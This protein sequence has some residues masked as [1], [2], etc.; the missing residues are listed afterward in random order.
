[1]QKNR[2]D[3]IIKKNVSVL[4]MRLP[5]HLHNRIEAQILDGKKTISQVVREALEKAL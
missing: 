5:L 3:R 2:F 1:M 4:R